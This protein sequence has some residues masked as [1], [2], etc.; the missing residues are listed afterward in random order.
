MFRNL[1]LPLARGENTPAK[2]VPP[3]GCDQDPVEALKQLF[4]DYFQSLGLAAGHDPATR[5]VFLRLHGVA[6]GTLAV[7][8]DLPDD[9]RVGVF[10]RKPEYP[11]WVRFSGDI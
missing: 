6:H 5:P 10:A 11:V 7:R 4:V 2:P 8:P 9:L 1:S 3:C